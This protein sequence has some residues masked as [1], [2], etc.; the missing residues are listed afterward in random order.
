MLKIDN[1]HAG[2]A[3]KE[4]LKGLS[5]EVK[6]GEVHAIMGPNGAGKST[7]GNVLAGRDGY[8]VT[9]GTVQFDDIALLELEPEER[10]AAG[11]FLAF[12][13]PVEIAG[14]NNTYFLRAALNAQRKARGQDELDSMQFLKLVRQKLAVLHLKDELLHRGVNEGFSGG[15]KKRNEIFQLAVLEPKLA[16]LD[17][18]DSGLDIDALKSVADG[19]NALRSPERSFVVITHYQR[20]LDYIKPDVVH[21]LAEG[22]IVKSGGPELALELEAHGYDFLKDRVVREAAQ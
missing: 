9:E 4:I 7:L 10:A 12:Q 22:R 6:P 14:V 21:V 8:E 19:V 18:T 13:Y 5:L 1:L 16:I 11:L 20:L 2:I 3:G 17:E 15:E